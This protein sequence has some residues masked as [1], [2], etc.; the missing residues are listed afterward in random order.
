MKVIIATK[1][2]GNIEGARRAF[3]KYF[4]NIDI[5]G[6][7]VSSDVNEQPV[8]EDTM[9]GAKNRIKNLKIYC[10]ENNIE[11]DLYLSIESG[12]VNVYGEWFITNIAVIEDNNN[13]NSCGIGQSFPV[14]NH[15]V[16]NVID[17]NFSKVIDEVFGKDDERHNNRG[18][19]DLL[20]KG[21]VSRIDLT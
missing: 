9:I 19:I 10:K 14:P 1:N 3:S 15:L 12:I 13:F 5:Q 6:I 16:N 7:S 20:T 21:N 17:T 11:A 8:N 18:G 2:P 4:E